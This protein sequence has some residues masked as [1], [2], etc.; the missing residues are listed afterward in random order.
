VAKARESSAIY[1]RHECL[2]HPVTGKSNDACSTAL[3][4]M[5]TMVVYDLLCCGARKELSRAHKCSTYGTS[6]LLYKEAKGAQPM[7]KQA[8]SK[9]LRKRRPAIKRRPAYARVLEFPQAKGRTVELVELIA[10][11]DY[12][13]LSIRFK[14]KT[15]LSVVIDPMFSF[16]A[17]FSD[18]KTHDQRRTGP[19]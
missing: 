16:R 6:P 8:S 18:W 7:K 11:T 13:C 9:S 4:G 19:V 14:D 15:D 3:C 5:I 2:L 12:H 1:R 17:N 10:D